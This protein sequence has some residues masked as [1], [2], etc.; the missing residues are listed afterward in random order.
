[1]HPALT[2]AARALRQRIRDRS[3]ILFAFLVPLGLAAA[4]AL[5]IPQGSTF[6]AKLVVYNADSGQLGATLEHHVLGALVD[7]GVADVTD[8]GSEA[9]ARAALD[10]GKTSVAILIPAG[11]SDA[12]EAGQA[13]TVR[14][15][16]IPDSPI[17]T[18]IA[19]SVVATFG[20]DVGAIQLAVA[21]S[22]DW[23]PGQ[24]VPAVDAATIAAIQA[25]PVAIVASETSME[26]RQATTATFYA[27][28]MAIMFLF[29]ATIYGPMGILGERRSG[30]LARL[31][32]A[33]IRPASI[34]LGASIASFVLGLF[35]MT[36]LIV[37]TTVLLGAAWGPPALVAPLAVAAV[38]AAMGVSILICT[39]ART[40]D[41]AGGWNAMVAITLAILGGSMI[42]LSSAPEILHQLS[43]L[44]PHAW[45]LRAIDAMSTSSVQ[46][47]D[48]LPSIAVLL[49]FGVVTG[50]IGLARSRTSLVAR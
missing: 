42:P 6:H 43:L 4:F 24:P 23:Q 1:M 13:T 39:V 31:L 33:P 18:E 32:A 44:T 49:G 30:T 36:T 5:L 38:I 35:S 48:I 12:V 21:T 8:V 26:R 11:F 15:I 17:A 46:L 50:A 40:E 34:V 10:D 2:I 16:G 20:S 25:T 7:T 47:T 41:Q 14:V 19:M 9:A 45:F 3:A 28:A 29:F 27:A 37:A 22:A